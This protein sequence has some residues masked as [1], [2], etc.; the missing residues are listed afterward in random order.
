MRVVVGDAADVVV[1][2]A[3]VDAFPDAVVVVGVF[4]DA[5]SPDDDDFGVVVAV[6]VVVVVC[7]DVGM[8]V[9]VF[10]GVWMFLLDAA[11]SC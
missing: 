5:A 9:F 6:V 7:N 2:D 10:D 3:F 4:V 11:F 8:F 1:G